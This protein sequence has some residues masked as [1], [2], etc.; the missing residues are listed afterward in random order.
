MNKPKWFIKEN[1]N[2]YIYSLCF[3]LLKYDEYDE[4]TI[5][6]FLSWNEQKKLKFQVSMK[7][8]NIS[9]LTILSTFYSKINKNNMQQYITK[10]LNTKKC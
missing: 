6:R 1:K 8:M 10:K 9:A 4:F 2:E 7:E 3:Y 5:E